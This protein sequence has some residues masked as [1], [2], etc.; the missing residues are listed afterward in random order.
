MPCRRYSIFHP[1][2][3]SFLNLIYPPLCLHCGDSLAKEERQFCTPCLQ[4]LALIEPSERC[5]LCFCERPCMRCRNH[6]LGL[7]RL[8]AACEREGP[9]ATLLNLLKRGDSPYLAKGAA[10]LM[11]AQFLRLEWPLPDLLVPIPLSFLRWWAH[12]YNP[13]EL[14]AH[15]LSEI[16]DRPVASLLKKRDDYSLKSESEISG[17]ILLLIDLEET[18]LRSCA[19]ALSEGE[20]KAI[21]GL[22]CF[23][24]TFC[25]GKSRA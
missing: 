21:Y 19:E 9:A 14:L 1:L 2:K 10:A 23:K 7:E 5:P 6:P 24:S 12:G 18:S 3:D 16:L 22:I 15:S 4:N 11:A 8:A 20:P 17:K 25:G 13:S